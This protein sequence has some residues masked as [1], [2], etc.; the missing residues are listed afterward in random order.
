MFGMCI[1]NA[2]E[3]EELLSGVLLPGMLLAG[4]VP[5][6]ACEICGALAALPYTTRYRLYS[7]LRVRCLPSCCACRV[8]PPMMTSLR[9][10]AA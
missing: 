9:L 7:E 2:D 8:F 1:V 10:G 5:A 3:V 6:V 4:A